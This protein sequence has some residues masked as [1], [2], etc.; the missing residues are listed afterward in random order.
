MK[1][2]YAKDYYNTFLKELPGDY[3]SARW[4]S[5]P[6]ATLDYDQTR[7]AIISALPA[8]KVESLLEIGPGDGVWTDLF[9][10]RAQTLTLLDQSVEMIERAKKRLE[11]T[12]NITF[13]VGDFNAYAGQETYDTICAI[14][15]FEYFEDKA[16]AIRQFYR[17]LKPGGTL[18][19]VTKNP[20]HARTKSAQERELHTGQISKGS[21]LGL[22][23]QAGFEAELLMSATWRFKAKYSFFRALFRAL[24]ALHVKTRGRFFIPFLTEPLTESYLYVAKKR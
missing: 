14:R 20:E 6:E 16:L 24:Q 21:M 18:I 11:G 9:I 3:K 19:I 8:K 2:A 17:L 12:P 7:L 23:R 1:N 4:F 15:C 22:L 10:P 13:I 5:S